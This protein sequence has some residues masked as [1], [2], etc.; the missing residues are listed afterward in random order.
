MKQFFESLRTEDW[1]VVWVSIP[2][3]LLSALIPALLPNVPSTLATL[4]A[5][6]NIALLFVIVLVVL[7]VGNRLL[8]RPL[9]GLFPS[10]CVVFAVSLLAQ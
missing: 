3:L 10:L 5:W 1:V 7:Y 4:E 8:G 9:R 6:R 2:L